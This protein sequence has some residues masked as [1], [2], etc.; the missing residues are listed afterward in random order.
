[1]TDRVA[2]VTGGLRGLGRGMTLG[3]AATGVKVVA[4]GHLAEDVAAMEGTPNVR[5]MVA[6]IRSGEACD[7]IVAE[8]RSAFG[9]LDILVNNAGL[10][11]TYIDPDRFRRENPRKFWEVGDEVVQN[12][13]DTNFVAHD[14]M[15]RRVAPILV[16][17]GWG[18]IVN[19]TTMLATMNRAGCQPYGSSKA[20]L[21]MATEIWAKELVD[22]GVTVNIVNPGAGANTPGM[23]REMRDW[24]REGKRPRLVEPDEM[25]PPLLY[26]VSTAADKVNGYRFDALTW[27]SSLPPPVAARLNG[28]P[29]GFVLHP[30]D[31]DTF[32]G[33]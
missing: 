15:T 12:V 23:A 27:D 30:R 6:D 1:M 4:V 20:A 17:Q 24:S 26:V 16:K 31:V 21:E 28:R 5:A 25:V 13:M 3:L 8:A 18:R 7:R 29:A 2:I 11:F 32:P 10:T 22:T 9:R 19:V 14:K 33:E